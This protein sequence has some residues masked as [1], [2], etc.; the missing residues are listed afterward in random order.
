[1][2]RHSIKEKSDCKKCRRD[3]AEKERESSGRLGRVSLTPQPRVTPFGY[4]THCNFPIFGCGHGSLHE[5]DDLIAFR[6]TQSSYLQ[7]RL[8]AA[9]GYSNTTTKS[10]LYVIL[11]DADVSLIKV[12]PKCSL[13]TFQEING[14]QVD[15]GINMLSLHF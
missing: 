13:T 2:S 15:D 10:L 7:Y 12:F 5:F 8:P 9:L 1:M 3:Q 4:L 14:K 11:L 6:E